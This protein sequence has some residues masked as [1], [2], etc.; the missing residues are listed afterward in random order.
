MK[1]TDLV[2]IGA[3]GLG[4][5]IVFGKGL[6]TIKNLGSILES[7]TSDAAKVTA[8]TTSTAANAIIFAEDLP[9][10][11]VSWLKGEGTMISGNFKAAKNAVWN[12]F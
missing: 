7:T 8:H 6:G 5:W 12:W 11:F 4:A 9:G 1:T 2:W 3:A 10:N